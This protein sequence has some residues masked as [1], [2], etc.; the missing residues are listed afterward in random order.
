VSLTP[1]WLDFLSA[2]VS[3]CNGSLQ[4]AGAS[5]T[6]KDPWD[7]G[8]CYFL[9]HRFEPAN[10]IYLVR[11]MG[12]G[13]IANVGSY[14]VTV[15]LGRLWEYRNAIGWVIILCDSS[16]FHPTQPDAYP[17]FYSKD[18]TPGAVKRANQLSQPL[19]HL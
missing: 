1:L 10:Q 19:E 16:N 2:N 17:H 4:W 8:H 5:I 7:V 15:K 12:N 11:K 6:V 3:I 9:L 13:S 18:P 14:Q